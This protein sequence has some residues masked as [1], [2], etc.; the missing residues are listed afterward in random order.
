MEMCYGKCVSIFVLFFLF[1][2]NAEYVVEV[3]LVVFRWSIDYWSWVTIHFQSSATGQ[4]WSVVAVIFGLDK[5]F[6]YDTV[7]QMIGGQ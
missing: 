2:F 1:F 4:W 6:C 7:G 3:S 5:F